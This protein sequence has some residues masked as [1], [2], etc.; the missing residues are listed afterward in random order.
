MDTKLKNIS[1]SPLTKSIASILTIILISMM[2][3]QL[4]YIDYT[5]L[6]IESIFIT[7]YKNSKVFAAEVNKAIHDT[8]KLLKSETSIRLKD[9][10]YIYLVSDNN[11]SLTNW[12]Y[13]DKEVYE[14]NK[15]GFFSYE[16]GIYTVGETTNSSLINGFPKDEQY[17]MY[18][19]FPDRFMKEQQKLW[20]EA[21]QILTQI[22]LRIILCLVLSSLLLFYLISVT[23]RKVGTDK[24]CTLWMDNVYT[25]VLFLGFTP[26]MVWISFLPQIVSHEEYIGYSL[27]HIQMKSMYL[28]GV[29]TA[30]TIIICEISLLSWIRKIKSGRFIKDSICHKIIEK[31]NMNIANLKSSSLTKSLYQRQIIFIINSGILI[32][33]IFL[34]RSIPLLVI[35]F[36]TLEI[37]IIYWYIKCNNTTF[38]EINKGFNE[39]LEE[40]MKS[41][42]MKLDL[43]TN[44]SHDLKTPLTSIISYI[45]L[46]SKEENL[47]IEARDYVSILIEKSNRLKNIVID[48]FDL[49]KSTSGDINLEL[50]TIDL[51]KLIEQTLGDM[52]DDI[53]RTG[54]Q[55]KAMLP[56]NSVNIVADGKRLYRVFQNIIDNALKYSLKGTR[57]FIELVEDDGEALVN[58]KNIAGYEMDFTSKEIIQRFS[59]GDQSRTTEGSGLGLSIAESF[60]NVCGGNFKIDIDGDMFKVTISFK[61]VQLMEV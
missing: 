31:I 32:L 16:N 11:K 53:E 6:E 33:F 4:V 27:N 7:E 25:E 15:D 56:E 42:R 8:Y 17:I 45:D 61:A 35:I 2:I 26:F 28:I 47:S 24:L 36:L 39:S 23:G 34:S 48:L 10:N 13:H 52:E 19:A 30:L 55:I 50:E 43:I 58:I 12:F 59:R 5:N 54:L 18:I 21:G 41:E 1:R 29:I 49:A 37:L 38:D 44:V 60:T 40:Q 20:N 57:I 22:I 14:E 3:L 46:L 9:L 51:K